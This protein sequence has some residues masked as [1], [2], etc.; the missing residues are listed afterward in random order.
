MIGKALSSL[1]LLAPAAKASGLI[2]GQLDIYKTI[3]GEKD[4]ISKDELKELMVLHDDDNSCVGAC[5]R[6]LDQTFGGKPLSWSA[7]ETLLDDIYGDAISDDPYQP[8]VSVLGGK[9]ERAVC[10]V[11][12]DSRVLTFTSL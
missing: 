5:D 9:E 12:Q 10:T 8:Q 11:A 3:L 2:R 7:F 4:T 6:F 1:L